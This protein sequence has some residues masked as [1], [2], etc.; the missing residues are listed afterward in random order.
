MEESR[1][2]LLVLVM[3]TQTKTRIHPQGPSDRSNKAGACCDS[4]AF[5][6]VPI[7]EKSIRHTTFI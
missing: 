2:Y 3:L 5:L 6:R 7:K 1:S 4:D